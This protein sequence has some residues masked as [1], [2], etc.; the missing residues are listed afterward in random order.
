MTYEFLLE[1]LNSK[2]VDRIP[3]YRKNIARMLILKVQNRSFKRIR[4]VRKKS[5]IFGPILN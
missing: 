5:P 4:I 3:S 2:S 1:L